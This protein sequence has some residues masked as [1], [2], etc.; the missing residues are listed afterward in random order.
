MKV[1]NLFDFCIAT[2]DNEYVLKL[3]FYLNYSPHTA[4]ITQKAN[5]S[6]HIDSGR[7]HF[8]RLYECVYVCVSI[9]QYNCCVTAKL[10]SSAFEYITVS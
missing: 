5:N 7:N 6:Y 1:M 2:N 10:N 4:A 3:Y 8:C 9:N